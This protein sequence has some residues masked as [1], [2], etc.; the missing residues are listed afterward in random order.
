MEIG[1]RAS[2]LRDLAGHIFQVEHFFANLLSQG[3]SA[4]PP[5]TPPP[6]LESP[7]LETLEKMHRE[8]YEKLLAYIGSASEEELR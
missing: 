1:G 6:K 2:T 3:A 5:T 8:A 4:P 7:D